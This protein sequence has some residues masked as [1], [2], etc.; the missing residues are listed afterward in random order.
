MPWSRWKYQST[1]KGR[2]FSRSLSCLPDFRLKSHPRS[3]RRSIIFGPFAAIIV[4]VMPPFRGASWCGHR[5]WYTPGFPD[6]ER[7][8]PEPTC[9]R[10]SRS[11]RYGSEGSSMVTFMS[12]PEA[13]RPTLLIFSALGL[14]FELPS[15]SFQEPRFASS[16]RHSPG[17]RNTRDAHHRFLF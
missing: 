12:S 13:S 2:K 15:F 1:P 8:T 6:L 4:A 16:A 7:H 17:K 5:R 9:W 3:A 11:I 10:T 14:N